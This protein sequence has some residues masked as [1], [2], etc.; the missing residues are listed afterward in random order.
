MSSA[1]LQISDFS[2]E[3]K[4]SLINILNNLLNNGPD[5]EPCGIP[6]QILDHL[7]CEEPTLVLCFFKLRSY[8]TKL[9]LPTSNPDTYNFAVNKSCDKHSYALEKSIKTV[10]TEAATRGVL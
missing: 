1:K 6:P 8:N 2:T 7:L 10:P 5:I 4:I 3:K 9:R